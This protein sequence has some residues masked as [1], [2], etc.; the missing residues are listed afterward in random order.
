MAWLRPKNRPSCSLK[1][2]LQGAVEAVHGRLLVVVDAVA[3]Q[4]AAGLPPLLPSTWAAGALTRL[5]RLDV[6]NYAD[7]PRLACRLLLLLLGRCRG[8]VPWHCVAAACEDAASRELVQ[9]VA[10]VGRRG[11]HRG[12]HRCQLAACRS[13][14]V[15]QCASVQCD[16]IAV[17]GPD[18][19]A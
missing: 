6:V 17:H 15:Q 14:G 9:N 1:A 3:P 13:S 18:R 7:I 19:A 12:E 10:A 5:E 11:I 2:L 16:A 4:S 8:A